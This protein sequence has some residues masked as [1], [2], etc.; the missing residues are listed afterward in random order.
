M[1]ALAMFSLSALVYVETGSWLYT[2]GILLGITLFSVIWK[3]LVRRSTFDEVVVNIFDISILSYIIIA[4]LIFVGGAIFVGTNYLVLD[5]FFALI[6]SI[7]GFACSF[8]FSKKRSAF[9]QSILPVYS[10]FI[11]GLIANFW[12]ILRP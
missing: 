5:R 10:P 7:G 6:F 4:V 1:T 3:V 8:Y 9:M 12:L 2:I 11:I